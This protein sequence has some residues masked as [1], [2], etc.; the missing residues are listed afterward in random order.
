MKKVLFVMIILILIISSTN[1]YAIEFPDIK[2]DAPLEEAVGVLAGYGIITGYPDNSFKPDQTVTRAEMAKIIMVSAGFSDYIKNMTSV[3]EDMRGH[4][5]ESYVELANVLGF[6]KGISPTMYGPDNL[7]KFEEAYTMI[8]RLLGYSDESLVGNWPSNYHEKAVA[9][10]LFENIDSTTGFASRRNISIMLYNALEKNMVTVKDNN[11]I[12]LT[13]RKLISNIGKKETKEITIKELSVDNFDYTDYLFNKWD[14]YY[15]TKGNTVHV[16]NPQYNEFSGTVTSLLT[17]RVIFVTDD[18]GNVRVFQVPDIPI[19]INGVK[20]DFNDLNEAR[21]KIVYEDDSFNGDVIGIIAYKETDLVVVERKDLYQEGSKEFAGKNLPLVDSEINYNKLHIKG[22]ART[23]E[24]ISLHDVVYFYET[25]ES[26]KNTSLTLEV[27]RSKTK[28]VVT[29]VQSTNGKTFYTV[30]NINYMTGKDYIFTEEANLNDTVDLILDKNNNIIKIYIS[31]Y[32]K[33]PST[34]GIVLSSANS[35]GNNYAS[36]RILDQYGGLKTYSLANNSNAV[37]VNENESN[38]FK[39]VLLKNNDLIKFDPVSKGQVKIIDLLPTKSIASSYNNQTRVLANGYYISSDTFILYGRNGKYEI[40]ETSQLNGYLE[41]KAVVNYLGHIDALYLTK[42]MK[43]SNPITVA[44]D[45]EQNYT[46]TVYGIIRGVT[47][48]DD[49]TSH[50]QFFNSSNVFSLS[51]TSAP[52]KKIPSLMNSYVRAGIVNGVIT[53]IERVTPET[54]RITITQIFTNQMLIDN[55][56]Y[57]EYASDI[58]VY[59]CS[60]DSSGNISSF[61]EGT[62]ADIKAGTKAQLYDLYGGFDGIIDVVLL[63]K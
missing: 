39:Q 9:L 23:L 3:Y 58:K 49:T 31:K 7:I 13:S 10:N 41:G 28:G 42:G 21:I 1:V 20:G 5:A 40:L 59:I 35:T 53:S 37:R 44:P 46:G 60:L 18:Y 2:N 50:L 62:K 63:F 27:L 6:I 48:I 22:D 54:E 43:T 55:I 11:S 34:Y 52:G 19:V 57:M 25:S 61:K 12:S 45:T 26:N 51:N 36:A 24:E 14:V 29:N 4:W 32:G 16:N 8:L 38:V 15:D 56:T 17:N 33:T 30:N 47:K